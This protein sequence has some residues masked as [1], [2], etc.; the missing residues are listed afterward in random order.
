MKIPFFKTTLTGD[1][2]KYFPAVFAN[3]DAFA[4]KPLVTR[5][6]DWMRQHH[7]LPNFFL[8]K[9]CTS[10]LELA[11]LVLGLKKGDEVII[12]SFAFVS[13]SNAFALRGAQCVFVDIDP[14]AM[15]IDSAQI[16]AAITPRTKAIVA[17][18]YAS[19]AC[20]YEAI[21]SVASR[22]QLYVVEDNAHGILA[23]DEK[24]RHLGTFGDISTFSF[25]H[26]KNITCGQGGGIAIN[27]EKL[28]ENFFI[29]YEFGTN[30]RSFFRGDA[31]RYEWK[32]LGSNYPLSE[33]NAAMLLAQLENGEKINDRFVTLWNLY[34]KELANF[35]AEGKITL[36]NIEEN[37]KHNAHCFYI[38]TKDKT[39]RSALIAFLNQRNISAQFH[40]TPL[41][42]SEF[43]R[44]AGRFSGEDQFTTR[45]SERLL[46][47]PLFYNMTETELSQVVNAL[48]QF[49]K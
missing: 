30:R 8:T 28:L 33:L 6:E 38:K 2:S 24:S 12:P 21:N 10:S 23:R 29:H 39:E 40:Y 45:E 34:K 46:R 5:C 11:A 27:N 31:N 3:D 22:H 7:G 48:Q 36:Q 15:N 4:R 41:H 26:L 9:S 20:N 43:G 37:I 42:S 18:N 35:E 14:Q 16:E 32:N 1:E 25:D 49:Y 17:L 47:L 44:K 13:C 19:V